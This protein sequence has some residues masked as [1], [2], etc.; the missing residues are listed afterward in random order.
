MSKMLSF[1]VKN[2]DRQDGKSMAL[3]T[4]GQL[5]CIPA[6]MV[7]GM[8]GK[9]LPLPGIIV[10]V[11]AG[12][13]ILLGCACFMGVRSCRTGLPATIVSAEGLGVSGARCISAL[14]ISI[15]SAG[16]FGIQ[17]AVCGTSFSVM[18]EENL[19]IC[20]PVWSAVFFWGAVMTVSAIN[21]Y[22]ILKFLYHTIAPVLFFVLVFT[23][24]RVVFFSRTGSPAALLAWR[25][26]RPIS[27]VTGTTLVVGYWA[28]GSF[29]A[30]DYCR[31]GKSPRGTAL[32]IFISIIAVL[33]VSFI[34]GAIF[35]ILMGTS[36]MTA[37]LTGMG[38]PAVALIS[39]ILASWTLNMIN[40]YSGGIALSVLLGLTVKRVKLN[41]VL[42]GILGTALGVAGILSLFTDFLGLLSSFVPPITGVLIGA[43][44]MDM[45][46]RWRRKKTQPEIPGKSIGGFIL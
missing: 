42:M 2:E 3:I 10:C 36:D 30:G 25:P 26:A 9:G 34:G 28:M 19:G 16:W 39:L 38:F 33:P 6:L 8:L 21:G 11:I 31:Y 17:A 40:A 15:T 44:I 1:K 5:I 22:R 24:I 43:R 14:L 7:G 32:G 13:L 12:G 20:I 35:F 23:I 46:K 41:T 37:I 4:A 18:V 27:Y 45:L 29:T